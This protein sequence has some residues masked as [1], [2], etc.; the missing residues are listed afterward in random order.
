LMVSV[1]T[2]TLNMLE[3]KLEIPGLG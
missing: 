1:V 3:K 2:K